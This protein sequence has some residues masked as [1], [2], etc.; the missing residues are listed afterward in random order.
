MLK[1][2]A[3]RL[4]KNLDALAQIGRTPEGGVS[5]P[6][7]SQADGAGRAWFKEVVE[8]AGLT[9]HADEAGNLSAILPYA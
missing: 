1:I 8:A 5:R 6:A 7:M 2:N 4:L 3:H 9:F